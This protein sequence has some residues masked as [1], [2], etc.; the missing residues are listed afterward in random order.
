MNYKYVVVDVTNQNALYAVC[1]SEE[2]AKRWIQ[3]VAPEH[4]KRG[5]FINEKLTVESFT[6]KEIKE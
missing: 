4:I 1:Y 5:Y 3:E 6:I 2:S